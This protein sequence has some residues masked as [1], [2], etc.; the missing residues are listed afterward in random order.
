M[1]EGRDSVRSWNICAVILILNQF[2][3]SKSSEVI[4]EYI[5]TMHLRR[6]TFEDNTGMKAEEAQITGWI[7]FKLSQ[8]YGQLNPL[9]VFRLSTNLLVGA[10]TSL[11]I[12]LKLIY[13]DLFV[14]SRT[15]R[16]WTNVLDHGIEI[17]RHLTYVW[18]DLSNKL[19][20]LTR[21]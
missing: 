7:V 6:N 21:D 19:R 16:E 14:N 3:W 12:A 10:K 1:V 11:E 18:L 4:V 9:I 20:K 13:V 15:E 5:P 17:F 8:R 2:W